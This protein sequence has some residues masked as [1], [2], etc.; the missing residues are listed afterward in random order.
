[1]QHV[2]HGNSWQEHID[3]IR[4]L[5]I[6]N[7]D[8]VP[9]NFNSFPW[10]EA[11]LVMPQ[12]TVRTQWN[13]A[14]IRKH[15]AESH[16]WLYIC[17]SEDTIGGR[18]VTNDEKIAIMTKTKGSR[19][20]MGHGGLMKEVELAIGAPVMVTLNILTDL[21]VAN[22]VRGMIE[23]IVFDECERLTITKED[24]SIQ[25]LYPLQYVLVKLDRTKAPSLEGLPQNVIPV[26]PVRKTFMINK[27]GVKMTVN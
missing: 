13:A 3:I 25:L 9:T 24:H 26:E 15:C 12:H 2:H 8:C 18:P 11:W 21:D 4:K 19:N 17:P 10:R 27:C 20:E 1:M 16:H 6:T 5:I 23:G 22:G 14:A 7:H